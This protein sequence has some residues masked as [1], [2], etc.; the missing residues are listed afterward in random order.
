VNGR[1]YRRPAVRLGSLLMPTLAPVVVTH[2]TTTYLVSPARRTLPGDAD[3]F[4]YHLQN[5]AL[6]P[7]FARQSPSPASAGAYRLPDTSLLTSPAAVC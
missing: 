4:T 1:I 6:L 7:W 2:A 5:K 3:M